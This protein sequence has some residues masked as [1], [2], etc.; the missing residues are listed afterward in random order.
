MASLESSEAPSA[1]AASPETTASVGADSPETPAATAEAAPPDDEAEL[2]SLEKELVEKDQRLSRS[3]IPSSRHQAV[4]T[5]NRRQHEAALAEIS[6]KYEKV[7]QFE[8]YD[9]NRLRALEIAEQDPDR[10]LEILQGIP[11]YKTRFDGWRQPT[12]QP[13]AP[14]APA[15]E[16]PK[17]DVLLSDGTLAYSA[18]GQEKVI[19]YRLAK[20]AE[21]FE[22]KIAALQG[23]VKPVLEQHQSRIE[24]EKAFVRTKPIIDNARATWEG[25]SDNEGEIQQ[26]WRANPRLTLE[27]AYQAVMIPKLKADKTKLAAEIK[28]DL[29]KEMNAASKGSSMVRGVLPEVAPTAGNTDGEIDAIIRNAVRAA[30]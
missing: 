27:G 15:L 18:E 14:A 4:L 21:A 8:N 12:S 7:K 23:T 26:V 6:A 25:F 19:E 29:I 2:G 17:P 22:Q 30:S 13:A 24:L 28:A 20:Q 16:A 1:E 11:E 9:Q 3:S 5:R 10:F